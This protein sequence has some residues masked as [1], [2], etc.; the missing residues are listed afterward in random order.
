MQ[1]DVSK[2]YLWKL[3]LPGL[4][5]EIKP[6]ILNLWTVKIYLSRENIQNFVILNLVSNSNQK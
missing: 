6:I 3:V 1:Y 2:D 4:Y 5:N